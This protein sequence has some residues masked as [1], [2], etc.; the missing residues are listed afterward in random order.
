MQDL[1][2]ELSETSLLWDMIGIG[3]FKIREQCLQ[4]GHLL[5][6]STA[7][8][9]QRTIVNGSETEIYNT[10]TKLSIHIRSLR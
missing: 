6:H 5:Y 8:N 10:K 1:G 3:E 9:E 4:S 2:E 7:N